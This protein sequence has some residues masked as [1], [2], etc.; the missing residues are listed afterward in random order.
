[1]TE[2]LE[3]GKIVG[4]HGV[5]GT[6]RVESYCDSPSVLAGLP[7]VYLRA[8]DGSY[9]RMAVVK[10]AVK[11]PHALLTLEGIDTPE[12]VLA[13][14]GR[15]LYA[16][17]EDIPLQEGDYF[18]ADLLG[19][20]VIDADSGV[21]YGELVWVDDAP[22]SM[23]YTVR[24]DSGRDVLFPAVPEFVKEIKIGECVRIRPIPGFFDEV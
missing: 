10:G 12:G 9:R 2:Y 8:A 13:L 15:V 6:A 19:L 24:T 17:R 7:A 20:P 18:I 1:M 3:C 23:L 21:R 22:A 16:H 4:A 14:R 5:R 11:P